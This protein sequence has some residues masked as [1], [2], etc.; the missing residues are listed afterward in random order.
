MARGL[1]IPSGNFRALD[2]SWRHEGIEERAGSAEP[3]DRAWGMGGGG[4]RWRCVCVG[5]ATD[6]DPWEY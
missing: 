6:R 1:E 5:Q 2:G 4:G 3:L